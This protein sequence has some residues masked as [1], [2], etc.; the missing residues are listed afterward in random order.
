MSYSL[1]PMTTL[2]IL[3]QWIYDW[4]ASTFLRESDNAFPVIET[5]HVLSVSL[6]AGSIAALD[7]RLMG[8]IFRDEPVE[9]IAATLLPWTWYGFVLMVLTGLPLF[10]S[11]AVKLYPNPAF[12]LK[13]ALLTLAGL[14]ALLF[15]LTTYR[16][17]RSWGAGPV[18]SSARGFGVISLLLWSGVIVSGR[19]IAVFHG[20]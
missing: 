15:H 7:L 1:A 9:R 11:E 3:C 20:H 6:I 12:R 10:A 16:S 2:Q 4:P 19:L 17:V 14:N 5:A 13:L 8:A 18:P